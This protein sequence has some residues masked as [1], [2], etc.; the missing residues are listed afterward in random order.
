MRLPITLGLSALVLLAAGCS[1]D[2]EP[3]PDAGPDDQSSSPTATGSPAPASGV[4]VCGLIDEQLLEELTADGATPRDVLGYGTENFVM[5]SVNEFVQFQFGFRVTPGGPGLPEVSDVAKPVEDLGDASVLEQTGHFAATLWTEQDG[6]LFIVRNDTLG[7]DDSIPVEQN[8]A[9]MRELIATVT[10][11]VVEQV[12]T[13]ELGD[14]CP[15]ADDPSVVAVV[16]AVVTARGGKEYDGSPADCQ[17]LG[18]GGTRTNLGYVSQEGAAADF[19]TLDVGEEVDMEGAERAVVYNP[20]PGSVNL[21]WA[22]APDLAWLADVT[23]LVGFPDYDNG[24]GPA[25]VDAV[26]ELGRTYM[27]ANPGTDAS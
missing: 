25:T 8:E 24:S 23:P 6:I 16:G 13:I 4:D 9:V 7:N 5:C 15:S 20:A 11:E 22:T 12:A 21:S 18:E 14:H 26:M 10:P 3:Q 2:D 1:S 19:V 17:Y 27:A